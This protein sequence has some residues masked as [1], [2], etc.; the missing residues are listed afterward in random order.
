MMGFWKKLG[1]MELRLQFVGWEGALAS[2]LI[3]N[4]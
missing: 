2:A 4:I 1:L 3:Y